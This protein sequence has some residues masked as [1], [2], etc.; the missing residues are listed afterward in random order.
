[1]Q[2]NCKGRQTVT[3][4][5]DGETTDALD[6]DADRLGEFRA[7]QIRRALTFYLQMRRGEFECPHC[8]DP[9]KY[10]P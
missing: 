5:V 3:A 7:D 9:I 8:N 4:K 10:D 2:P 6:A 1:M